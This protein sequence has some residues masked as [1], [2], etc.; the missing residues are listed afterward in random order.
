MSRLEECDRLAAEFVTERLG[1]F[2]LSPVEVTEGQVLASQ[3]SH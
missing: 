3:L 1:G 2:R